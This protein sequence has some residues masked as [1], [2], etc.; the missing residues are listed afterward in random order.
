MLCRMPIETNIPTHPN[1]IYIYNYHKYVQISG[2]YFL[3]PKNPKAGTAPPEACVTGSL[4]PMHGEKW[5]GFLVTS[6][7]FVGKKLWRLPKY[8]V[9]FVLFKVVSEGLRV[10]PKHFENHRL[11]KDDD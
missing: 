1:F 4:W 9:V 6:K 10:T 5:R 7:V 3:G 2:V 8:L 11:Q